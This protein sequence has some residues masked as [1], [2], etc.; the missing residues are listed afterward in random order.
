[1]QLEHSVLVE[2]SWR[3]QGEAAGRKRSC[4]SIASF[5]IRVC[6][7][8]V[9]VVK[10]TKKDPHATVPGLMAAGESA[11]ASVHGANR[12]G[13]N[14]LLDIV[15]FGRA[16]ALTTAEKFTPGAPHK[17][18]PADAGEDTIAR[19]DA[20]RHANGSMKVSELRNTMQ[21][22]MQTNAAVFRTQV[23]LAVADPMCHELRMLALGLR[24]QV[25]TPGLV[26]YHCACCTWKMRLASRGPWSLACGVSLAAWSA[27]HTFLHLLHLNNDSK[28]VSGNKWE[29]ISS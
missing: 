15:V 22:V 25:H 9:Q 8:R 20:M 16:C 2:P 17:D 11:C 24:C 21:R 13:A 23:R 18:L 19:M 5:L 7:H 1:M 3:H 28:V 26:G 14:S 6:E 27:A 12:L 29:A 10:P 4:R